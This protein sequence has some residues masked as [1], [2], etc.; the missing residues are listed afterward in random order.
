MASDYS[1]FS[2]SNIRYPTGL[3]ASQSKHSQ[4]HRAI[5][6]MAIVSLTL[7]GCLARLAALQI[8]DGDRNR[9]LAEENRIRPVP[10]PA[11][12]GNILD[13]KSR[14]LAANRLTRSLYLWPRE[15]TEVR[16][17][18]TAVKLGLIL[19]MPADEIL[20]KLKE[21]GYKAAAPIRIANELSQETFIS[22][23]ESQLQLPGI[24]IRGESNRFYPHGNLASHVLGYIGE[25]T[26]DDLKA[27]PSWPMGSIVGRMGIERIAD[28]N[29]KGTWGSHLIEM[30]AQGQPLRMLGEQPPISGEPLQLT[31]DLDLQETAER[32]LAQR[33]GA[34]VV[35]DIKTG[36]V[37][38]MASGPSF[39][40]N[41][42]TRRISQAEWNRLQSTDN[43]F[44][45]RAL[46][47]YPPAST[48]KI[49]SSTA[50]MESGKF[51]PDSRIATSAFITV[52]GFQFNEHGGG[53]GVI[54]FRDALAVSSNTFFYQVGLA[55][56]PEEI[57]KWAKRLGIGTTPTMNLDGASHGMVPTP[58]E[59][60]KLYREPW[61]AGDTVSTA[62]GQGLVQ[63]TPLESAVVVSTI[64][65]G[66]KRVI[67]H[68]LTSQTNSALTRPQPTGIKAST[69]NTIRSG[70]IAVV[71]EGTGRSLN[72]GSIPLTAGKTG[73]AEVVGQPNNSLWVGYGPVDNPQIA[74]AVMIENGGYGATAAVPVAHEIY[75]TYFQKN[76]KP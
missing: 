21:A 47:G 64:A 22:L 52:G 68:L 61:Y 17:Q 11:S 32:A 19:K 60:E 1:S 38:V 40:P 35:L 72:D 36:G 18:S 8:V 5:A 44:L 27:N 55:V 57:A 63:V 74:I 12:R 70:L 34:V 26:L 75:K 2:N 9:Q 15:Q 3:R 14:P 37:L 29:L 16:W 20:K 41:I 53:Y 33:R 48:F 23:E 25:A 69:I 45:N 65:N 43:P 10:I 62:I 71:Q 51:T 4:T 76:K 73:T 54:G 7:G 13:R 58:A 31:L 56:G 50:A 66:G 30:D 49:V 39:D 6:F 28:N 42:F 24:E 67:P 46:Q 59:K